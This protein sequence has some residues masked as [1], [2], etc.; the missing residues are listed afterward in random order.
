M[1]TI[2]AR[3]AIDRNGICL[4]TLRGADL[5][6]DQDR[7]SKEAFDRPVAAGR[8]TPTLRRALAVGGLVTMETKC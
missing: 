7:A 2:L 8:P 1:R 3:A 6:T 5:L 4:I